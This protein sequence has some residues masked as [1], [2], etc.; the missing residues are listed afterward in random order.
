MKRR[1]FGE[2]LQRCKPQDKIAIYAEALNSLENRLNEALEAISPHVTDADAQEDI[3]QAFGDMDKGFAA[4][5]NNL[6]KHFEGKSTRVIPP[7]ID[8]LVKQESMTKE[9][10]RAR[11]EALW[12]RNWQIELSRV[13]DIPK[14]TIQKWAQ[15]DNPPPKLLAATLALLEASRL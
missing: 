13:T 7:A 15:G 2:N 9:E 12:G 14:S 4:L 6:G 8:S 5:K 1:S 3:S 11:G 10:L